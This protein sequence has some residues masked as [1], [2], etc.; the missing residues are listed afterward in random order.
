MFVRMLLGNTQ[1]LSSLMNRLW[2]LF[3]NQVHKNIFISISVC[4]KCPILTQ[5]CSSHIFFSKGSLL[6]SAHVLGLAVF[7]VHLQAS[8]SHNPLVQLASTVRQEPIPFRNVLSSA[9]VCS[10]LPNMLFCVRQVAR[11]SIRLF[12]FF[13]GHQK[14]LVLKNVDVQS[15]F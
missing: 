1:L 9:L 7:V 11:P 8:M 2:D 3:H 15:L 5:I 14:G 12:I 4:Q 10:T 13:F 6:N